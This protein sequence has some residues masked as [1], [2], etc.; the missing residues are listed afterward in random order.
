MSKFGFEWIDSREPH[1]R[2]FDSNDNRVATCYRLENAKLVESHNK[3]TAER[4][5]SDKLEKALN[6]VLAETAWHRI[7]EE[8]LGKALTALAEVAAIRKGGAV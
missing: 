3:L 7:G 2:V 4:E 5:V 1:Y 8:A 6:A